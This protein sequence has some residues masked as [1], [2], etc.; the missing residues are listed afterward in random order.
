LNSGGM[1]HMIRCDN[2]GITIM[3]PGNLGI[4]SVGDMKITSDHNITIECETLTM[5][6]RMHL[7]I[8]GGSS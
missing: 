1:A 3:T 4:H 5:Q 8:F 2:N 6:E 7:K